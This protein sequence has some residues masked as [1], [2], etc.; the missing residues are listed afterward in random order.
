MTIDAAVNDLF[1]EFDKQVDLT[2]PFMATAMIAEATRRSDVTDAPTNILMLDSVEFSLVTRLATSGLTGLLEDD[3]N[4]TAD[5]FYTAMEKLR[6]PWLDCCVR[7]ATRPTI[8]DVI[9]FPGDLIKSGLDPD[10]APDPS[11]F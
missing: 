11:I 8:A 10:A 7:L 4:V 9:P 2:V 1:G 3:L 5:E 6:C